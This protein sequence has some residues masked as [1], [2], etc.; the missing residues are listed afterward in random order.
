MFTKLKSFLSKIL[1]K[2]RLS[3]IRYSN[4][5][6]TS[7]IESGTSFFSSTMGRYSFCGYD[8]DIYY[9]NI[10]SFTSIANQV[11]I[12]GAS[13]PMDWVGMSPVF[14][15]GRDSINK[16]FSKYTL[17]TP[18]NTTI[19]NDVWIGRSAII[20]SGV[21]IG[22]GAVIGAGAIVAKDVPPYAIV[23]GNP[24]KLIRYRFS[25]D[26]VSALEDSK[27]WLLD[28]QSLNYLAKYIKN[29]E[30]FISEFRDLFENQDNEKMKK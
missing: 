30:Q 3:S 20:M 16:K 22:N 28:E 29:P 6:P 25:S 2:A 5:D 27:W 18:L 4:V 19:G 15:A 9:A 24:A 23:A 17:D 21:R 13:H 12:G 1:K 7:K 14:Y 10:G 8:C 11:V 26:L